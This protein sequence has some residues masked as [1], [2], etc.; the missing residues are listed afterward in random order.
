MAEPKDRGNQEGHRH[1]DTRV[2]AS[3][4]TIRVEVS[5][6]RYGWML[7]P[8]RKKPIQGHIVSCRWQD[9]TSAQNTGQQVL[10]VAIKGGL[11]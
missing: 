8:R 7:C 3:L 2:E 5:L 6:G 9:R 1:L 4:A 10:S 11:R